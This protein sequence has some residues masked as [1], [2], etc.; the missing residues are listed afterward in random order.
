MSALMHRLLRAPA[1]LHFVAWTLSASVT[2]GAVGGL[3]HLADQEYNAALLAQ[4]PSSPANEAFI[5]S[6]LL[7]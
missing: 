1:F 6:P 7:R 3:S 5:G 4:E 2:L